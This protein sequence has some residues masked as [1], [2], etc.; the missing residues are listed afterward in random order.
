MPETIL[1]TGASGHLGRGVI[2]HLLGTFGMEPGRIIAVTRDASKLADLAAQGVTVRSGDFDNQA[3]L[4]SA[5][6]GADRVLI[7]STNA[8]GEP[9]KRLRQHLSAIAAAKQAGAKHVAYTSMPEPEP[10]NAVLFAPDHHGTEQALRESGLPYTIFRNNW[11]AENLFM[12]LPKAFASGSWYTSA[13]DGKTAFVQRDDIAA[14]IAGGLARGGSDSATYTLTGGKA[15][16][17]GEIAEMASAAAGKPLAV[18]NLSDEALA[19][20]MKAAGVPAPVIPLLVSFD[21]NTRNGG[22]A[23][24]TGDVE[25]LS[26]RAPMPLD[27]FIKA[28]IA[29]LAG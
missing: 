11:Y 13:G 23:G 26:G 16:S 20:G 27:A 2:A 21:T 28:N 9:G 22:L 29:G 1:V 10:G 3:S 7:V 18:V 6:A 19:G 4:L 24:V 25:K 14:A 15:F 5:F 12:S 17:N 8:V